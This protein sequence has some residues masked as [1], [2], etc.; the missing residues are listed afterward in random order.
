VGWILD[1]PEQSSR[2]ARWLAATERRMYAKIAA[3][4]VLVVL[5]V[6]PELAV[7]RRPEDDPD[8]V[9]ARNGEVFEA[10]WTKTDAV[11]LDAA[12][13]PELVLSAIRNAVWDRL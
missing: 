9:R 7:A 1:R 8:Y 11:V 6:D 12:K 4:D 2:V 10:D 13:P 3:P 5:R